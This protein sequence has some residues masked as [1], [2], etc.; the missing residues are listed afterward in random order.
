MKSYSSC[1]C[2][3]LVTNDRILLFSLTRFHIFLCGSA[4]NGLRR[5]VDCDEDKIKTR[6]PE[7]DPV[8]LHLFRAHLGHLYFLSDDLPHNCCGIGRLLSVVVF[9]LIF[10]SS[11]CPS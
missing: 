3:A 8:S 10:C 4:T 6:V 1:I 5:S 7:L 9:L 2:T 11:S